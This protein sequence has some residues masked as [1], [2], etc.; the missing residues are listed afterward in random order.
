MA[1]AALTSQQVTAEKA[2]DECSFSGS[3]VFVAVLGAVLFTA[4]LTFAVVVCSAACCG[5]GDSTPADVTVGAGG[6]APGK[7]CHWGFFRFPINIARIYFGALFEFCL[8]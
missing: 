5:C 6:V 1:G 7:L 3:D 4:L 2:V 8:F